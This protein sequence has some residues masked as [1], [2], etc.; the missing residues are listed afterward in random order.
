MEGRCGP[1]PAKKDVAAGALHAVPEVLHPGALGAVVAAV[2]RAVSFESVPD[3]ARAANGAAWG[4]LL[5]GA[6]ER[7][8]VERFAVGRRDG[9][10]LV[11]G[12]SA[13][14]ADGH[15]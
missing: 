15:G 13:G 3:D 10:R 7:V 6:L 12:V 2:E 1:Q 8:E 4:Q 5:D 11:V 9:E 14:G